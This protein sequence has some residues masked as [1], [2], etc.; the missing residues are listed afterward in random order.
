MDTQRTLF[1]H[2]PLK[3][4]FDIQWQLVPYAVDETKQVDYV[5]LLVSRKAQYKC[6]LDG[7]CEHNHHIVPMV[8][9][10]P[11]GVGMARQVR[12]TQ[13]SLFAIMQSLLHNIKTVQ[14]MYKDT[15]EAPDEMTAATLHNF[16]GF[17]LSLLGEEEYEYLISLDER[18][19][20]DLI[21][22]I[23]GAS[24]QTAS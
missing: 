15:D 11:M 2:P 14:D 17:L 1:T 6:C 19:K 5:A 16:T 3:G 18:V 10:I 24:S 20:F 21:E 12:T 8:I 7:A 23:H 22:D 9:T 4:M 13:R